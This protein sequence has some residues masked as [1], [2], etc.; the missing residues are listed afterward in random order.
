MAA[1]KIPQEK[2]E[3]FVDAYC[4]TW[5]GVKAAREAGYTGTSKV[6]SESARKLLRRDDVKAMIAAR[7]ETKLADK[8]ATREERQRFWTTVMNGGEV[9]V[10]VTTMDGRVITRMQRPSVG[11][12]MKASEL[13]GKSEGDF[14]KKVDVNVHG[15]VVITVEVPDNGRSVPEPT[16][17]G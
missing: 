15:K 5:N 1:K 12:R 7:F 9:A 10:S 4:E 6:L 8:A 2:L 13:L 16:D 3:T 11:A 17:N 14:V